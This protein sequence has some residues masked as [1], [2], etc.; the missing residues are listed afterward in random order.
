MSWRTRPCSWPVPARC[1]PRCRRSARTPTRPGSC[2][3]QASAT[4]E[5]AAAGAKA[6][7]QTRPQRRD[8]RSH[9]QPAAAGRATSS[10]AAEAARAAMCRATSRR[11]SSTSPR[12]RGRPIISP[13]RRAS[14]ARPIWS[15]RWSPAISASAKMPSARQWPA[16]C[17]PDA[18]AR[19]AA[20]V[21]LDLDPAAPRLAVALPA[22]AGP[23]S[24]R[25]GCRARR[26]AGA[27]WARPMARGCWS[28]RSTSRIIRRA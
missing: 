7:P 16:I 28:S 8:S 13:S 9:T 6:E 20:A 1:W 14:P 10:N 5:P 25:L 4:P 2:C 21:A 11:S 19:R 17:Q 22:P 18:A 15:G 12:C 23:A 27:A 26:L 3:R 24:G